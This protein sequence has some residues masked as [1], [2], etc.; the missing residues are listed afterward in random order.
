MSILLN[1]G[2]GTFAAMASVPAEVG[3]TAIAMGDLDADNDLDLAVGNMTSESIS[4]LWN[5]GDGSFTLPENS[6]VGRIPSSLPLSVVAE[7]LD[8]ES[9]LDLAVVIGQ[10]NRV[11]VLL[12]TLVAGAHRLT[13]VGGEDL[14]GNF[15][16]QE[17]NHPPLADPAGPYSMGEGGTII[18]DGSG[19]EDTD[20]DPTTLTY[21][22]DFDYDGGNFDVEGILN[23][24]TICG[25]LYD[26]PPRPSLWDGGSRRP[27][28]AIVQNLSL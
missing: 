3:P 5:L 14:T 27:R 21:E 1:S 4:I 11:A 9:G 13:L 2:D 12:N 23:A 16:F 25:N 8:G 24:V 6:G 18:L 26:G 10:S 22:W 17:A 20:Q 19:S 7:D 15:A 28:R